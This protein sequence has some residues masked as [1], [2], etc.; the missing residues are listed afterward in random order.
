MSTF[1]CLNL[2]NIFSNRSLKDLTQYPVFPWILHDY[3]ILV[4]NK[5]EK[6][7]Q[8]RIRQLD[9]PMAQIGIDPKINESSRKLNYETNYNI[10]MEEL[11]ESIKNYTMEQFYS[12][13]NIDLDKV[14][15]YYGT[16]Y[17]NPVHVSHYLTRIFPYTITAWKLMKIHLMT[18]IDYLL[19]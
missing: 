17:S 19:I 11:D 9:L 1:K 12:D 10:F 7:S 8:L 13:N 16:H 15:Y 6:Q 4:Y 2:I 18:L 3:S 14:P 5:K